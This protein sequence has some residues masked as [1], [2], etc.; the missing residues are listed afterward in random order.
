MEQINIA[1]ELKKIRARDAEVSSTTV[2]KTD[3][4]RVVLMA[5]KA[6]AKL[7][8]HHADGRLLLQVLEGEIEFSAENAKIRLRAGMLASVEALVP[9]A[10]EAVS[11]AVLLLT[12]A[13]RPAEQA[14]AGSHRDVGYE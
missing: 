13:W 6:G 7:H 10:V 1:E 14:K 5:L 12:I 3:A 9:H 4:L 11:D 8:E 2:L